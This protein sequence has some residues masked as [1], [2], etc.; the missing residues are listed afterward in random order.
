MPGFDPDEPRDPLG[1][2]TA[3]FGS[4][5]HK[6]AT[7]K[8]G[9]VVLDFKPN[10][11]LDDE[12]KAVEAK[13]IKDLQDNFYEREAQYLA[14]R[15]LSG[16]AHNTVSNDN[17]KD[18][19][20]DYN[21]DKESRGQFAP[22]A[23]EPASAF[24]KQ[25]YTD[26]LHRPPKSNE[27][28]FTGGG[29]GAG[30]TT[31][32]ETVKEYQD[33]TEK[34]DVVYDSNLANFESSKKKIDEALKTG[35]RV[36]IVHVHREIEDAFKEGVIPRMHR[37]GRVVPITEHVT[38]TFEAYST[39]GQLQKEYAGNDKVHFRFVDNS[40]GLGKAIKSTYEKIGKKVYLYDTKKVQ[41]DLTEYVKQ[42]YKHG[43]IT[44]KQFKGLTTKTKQ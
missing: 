8:K 44:E 4:A 33:M 36:T 16:P 15:K 3:E 14:D 20:P 22:A 6:A 18:L 40:L 23:H 26:L 37:Q 1:R 10:P 5:F 29:T 42:E 43:R 24:V 2:W 41:N 25:V 31:A 9:K 38:R 12:Q 35:R 28:V 13:F 19:S 17:A 11:H 39:N 30:K 21:K 34:A 32:I 27:V 7:D